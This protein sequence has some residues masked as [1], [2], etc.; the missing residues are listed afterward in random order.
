[1]T[2]IS[3]K[4]LL[5]G[6]SGFIGGRLRD[7]LLER[8]LDVIAIRR[9]G[10]PASK[11]GRSV[12]AEYDDRAALA[13]IVAAEKPDYVLHVAGATKGVSYGDFHRANVV[14][15]ENLIAAFEKEHPALE[16]FVFVS[17]LAAF[18]PS[19][20]DR[21]HTES[22]IRRPIEFYGQSKLEAEHVVERSKLPFTIVRPSGV[23]GPG[24]ADYFNLFREVE[25]GRNVFFGNEQRVFSAIYVDDLIDAILRV[26]TSANTIGKGYFVDDG[27]IVTWG[28]FQKAIVAASGRRAMTLRL[29]EAF[30]SIAAVAGET[31]S[32]VDGKPRLFNRQKAKMGAQ[33]A[34]TCRS[35]N[36]RADTGW[37]PAVPYEEGVR[38]AYAWYRAEKWL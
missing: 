17:S 4:V 2:D 36:L 19:S 31:A 25:S 14:P 38:R 33:E 37:S 11:K 9:K 1:M 27:R 16:R 22:D 12:E 5:T 7:T 20:R 30:V 28:E 32:R 3:G 35:D 18:G 13:K 10:S 21:A 29:P 6:A 15:T 26:T 23:Y 24:D 8:G 34:W